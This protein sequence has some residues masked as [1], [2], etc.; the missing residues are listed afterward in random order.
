MKLLKMTKQNRKVKT[1]HDKFIDALRSGKI[2]GKTRITLYDPSTRRQEVHEDKNMITSSLQ[3]MFDTNPFGTMDFYSIMNLK[4]I[5]GGCFLFWDEL[6]E[7]VDNIFPPSQ[8][9]NKLTGHAG[10]T[11]HQTSSPTR[12]NPNGAASYVDAA[13]GQVKIVWDF[14]LEQGNGQISAVS[15]VNP[16]AGDCG[17]YPDGSLP[18]LKSYGLGVLN[19]YVSRINPRDEGSLTS[20]TEEYSLRWPVKINDNGTGVS[21][22][23]NGNTLKENVVRHPFVRPCLCEGITMND[24]NNFTVISTRTATLSR[25]FNWEYS[26]IGQ[27]DNYYYVMERDSSTNTRL[28]LNIV[29]KSD[30]SVTAQTIDITGATLARAQIRKNQVNN[31]IVSGGFIYWVSG[32]GE[33]TFVRINIQTPADTT[34]LSSF[35]T[36]AISYEMQPVTRTAGLVLGRN[37]LINGDYVYPVAARGMRT[38]D[39]RLPDCESDALYKNGPMI[40][41]SGTW[42]TSSSI[43]YEFY[44]R[45]GVLYL[46]ALLSIN[47][48]QNPVTKQNN[49]TM[50]VEYLLTLSGGN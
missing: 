8:T 35:L 11:P 49:R 41:Q 4:D 6:T 27:D 18:L 38:D 42:Y 14:S 15:L 5:I 30:F 44:S 34:V 24:P 47:N 26:Q 37:F 10:Q 33:K 9:A 50:R 22:F 1:M 23:L 20:Y 45:G 19:N 12:G 43:N 16:G 25:S 13:N 40:V 17:L 21:I 2:E 29:S 48:L 32:A 36:G 3:K 28:Y 7:N 31:G 46:P 39:T